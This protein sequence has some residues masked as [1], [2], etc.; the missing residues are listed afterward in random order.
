MPKHILITGSTGQVGSELSALVRAKEH[1]LDLAVFYFTDRK[2][3][4]ITDKEMLETFIQKHSIDTIINCAAYTAVDKAEED[5][6]KAYAVNAEAVGYLAIISKKKE[7]QLIHLSSDYVFSHDKNTPL[8]ERDK[9]GA[10]GVYAQSKLAGEEALRRIA[11]SHAIIIRTAWVYSSFG[12]NFVK[13][14]L[15]L[16]KERES[17]SVVS[18]QVGTPTYARDLAKIILH[19]LTQEKHSKEVILY[20]Y[21][22]EGLCSWYDFAIMIF[23]LSAISCHINPIPSKDYPTPAKRPHYSVL[24]KSKIKEDFDIH[25]PHWIHSLKFCLE[26]IKLAKLSILQGFDTQTISR[27][28]S[29]SIEEIDAF[30]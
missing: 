25:I 22:N 30:R 1:H 11:P 24:N 18:D 6:D 17:I 13:T 12:N 14:M 4:D 8:D 9:V 10:K 5:S 28:T 7:I 29:L 19:I 21:T 27:I 23:E 15:R 2:T 16:G 26:E 20:N 3:L